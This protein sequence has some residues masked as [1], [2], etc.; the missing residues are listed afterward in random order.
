MDSL[1]SEM[2]DAIWDQCPQVA[3]QWL[4]WELW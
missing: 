2:A 1:F 3:L 4:V